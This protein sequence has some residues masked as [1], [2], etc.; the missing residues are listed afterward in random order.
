MTSGPH[1]PDALPPD[2][3]VEPA[4]MEVEA[5]RRA[6][7]AQFVVDR[8]TGAQA[9][10]R[11]AMDPANQSLAE[12]LRLSFRVLQVVIVILIALFLFSGFQTVQEGYTGV[13]TVADLATH[14][15]FIRVSPAG[16]RESHPHDVLITKE[17]PNYRGADQ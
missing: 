17:A 13:R 1:Q 10:M 2:D 8:A 11:E 14:T 6:S 12:A 7:S 15:R 9:A 3:G 16:M 4:P 5:P